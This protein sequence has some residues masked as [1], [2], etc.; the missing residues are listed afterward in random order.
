MG[1]LG[2]ENE[3]DYIVD[4]GA[5][6][7]FKSLCCIIFPFSV[8]YI[9]SLEPFQIDL[10]RHCIYSEIGAHLPTVKMHLSYSS[11]GT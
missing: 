1:N 2:R 5:G 4:W 6:G 9:F 7:L 8:I 3:A 10:L 11:P